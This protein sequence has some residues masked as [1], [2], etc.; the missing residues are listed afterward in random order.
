M[1]QGGVSQPELMHVL[2]T[3]PGIDRGQGQRHPGDDQLV[4]LVAVTGLRPVKPR[5]AHVPIVH[6]D[7]AYQGA[8]TWAGPAEQRACGGDRAGLGARLAVAGDSAGGN[9]AAAIA[10]RGRTDE[11]LRVEAQL[12][13]YPALDPRQQHASHAQFADGYLLTR[14]DMAFY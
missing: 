8:G 14:S 13:V 4:P 3:G 5:A 7:L 11:H 6:D 2:R 1:Q 9:L 10:A 12:L